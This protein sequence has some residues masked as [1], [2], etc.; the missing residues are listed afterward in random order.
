MA[1]GLA[2]GK[3]SVYLVEML[4]SLSA[5]LFQLIDEHS[6]RNVHH[7]LC[8][9]VVFDHSRHVQVFDR[10]EVIQ[11]GYRRCILLDIVLSLI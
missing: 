6:K 11:L 7:G 10:Y 4:A 8:K 1:A 5:L 3:P 9:A 2:G